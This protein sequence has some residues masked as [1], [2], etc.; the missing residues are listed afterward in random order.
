MG[1]LVWTLAFVV[2]FFMGWTAAGVAWK[3][4]SAAP[5]VDRLQDTVRRLQQQVDRLQARLRAREDVAALRQPGATALAGA[6]SRATARAGVPPAT[7]FFVPSVTDDRTAPGGFA[8]RGGAAQPQGDRAS[9]QPGSRGTVAA[10]PTAEAALERFYRYLEVTNGAEGR[11]RWRQVRELVDDLRGMGDVA[12]QALMQVLAAGS[13]SDERRAAARLLGTLQA[14]QSLP[15]L[16]EVL[17]K[18]DDV[19]LRRAVAT[20]LRQLQVPEAL[21][22]LDRLLSNPAEDR[23]VRLSA[24]YGLAESGRPQGVNGLVQIFQESTA[25]GRGREVAFRALV[26]L[27]DERSLP[28]MRQIVSSDVEPAYRLRAIKYVTAQGDRQALGALQAVIQSPTEQASIR[29]AAA[30]AYR[31]ITGR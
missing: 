28:F 16:R 13:D 10:P 27:N 4:P 14:P 23:M 26:S 20:G 3:G 24:A 25:D 1:R 15:L 22:V 17:D 6:P 19:L 9:P 5:E 11:E 30:H 29:D 7:S 31:V 2:T 18:E 8:R 12:A 21:P